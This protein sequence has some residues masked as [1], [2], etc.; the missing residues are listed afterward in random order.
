M[1]FKNTKYISYGDTMVKN[2]FDNYLQD[3]NKEIL[4][5]KSSQ[6]SSLANFRIYQKN[7]TFP[8]EYIKA[9]SAGEIIIMQN[10]A[11]LIVLQSPRSSSMFAS[12]SIA[13]DNTTVEHPSPQLFVKDGYLA[14]RIYV[15]D[16]SEDTPDS[17]TRNYNFTASATED[18]TISVITEHW[19]Y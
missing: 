16:F 3:I 19:R 15:N 8:V 18:F 10:S 2:N 9:T 4:A 11:P 7:G 13:G 12:I 6:P 17:F 14:F 5:I 1:F